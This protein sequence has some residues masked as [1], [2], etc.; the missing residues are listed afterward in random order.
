MPPAISASSTPASSRCESQG[1]GLAPVDGASGAFDWTGTIPFDEWPRLHNPGAG[2]AFNANNA[3]FPDD[4]EP[5]FGQDW[6]E[7]FRARRIQQFFDTIDKHSL[8]TSAEMQADHLSLD[9][10]ELQPFIATIAPTDERARKAQ[11][12]LLSWN[13]VMDKD[14]AEPLI[15][16]A[17]LRVAPHDPDRGQ[18][19]VCR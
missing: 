2:F 6:E 17:F 11:A 18:D 1:D 4:H 9:V 10:K 19:R 14:R 12:L 3:D 16:T 7:T 15:Y 13:G 5:R 8:D